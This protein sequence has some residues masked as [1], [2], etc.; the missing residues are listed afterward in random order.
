MHGVH[1]TDVKQDPNLPVVYFS[2]T[3]LLVFSNPAWVTVRLF[4]LSSFEEQSTSTSYFKIGLWI[5]TIFPSLSSTY[6][7]P[8]SMTSSS[9]IFDLV[10][11][12]YSISSILFDILFVSERPKR[13]PGYI[14]KLVISLSGV[15]FCKCGVS[16]IIYVY[17][18][19]LTTSSIILDFFFIP[20]GV[21][22]SSQSSYSS[23][24]ISPLFKLTQ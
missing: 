14:S 21:L 1:V 18:G 4:L 12:R 9:F 15:S 17:L 6:I 11:L 7:L 5:P 2:A 3:R 24:C 22:C 16:I 19:S 10:S 23:Y 8:L 13:T 20:Y